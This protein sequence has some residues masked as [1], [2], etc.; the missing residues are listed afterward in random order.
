MRKESM[1]E[2]KDPKLD[3]LTWPD[4]LRIRERGLASHRFVKFVE[5]PQRT[6]CRLKAVTRKHH[7]K[8][9]TLYEWSTH[10]HSLFDDIGR[11]PYQRGAHVGKESFLFA[12]TM[13]SNQ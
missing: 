2:N 9:E 5:E 7:Y 1:Q 3:T 4:R 11:H 12:T 10:L 8:K 13:R 6:I